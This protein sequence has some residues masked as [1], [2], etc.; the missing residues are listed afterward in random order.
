MRVSAPWR[1]APVPVIPNRNVRSRRGV[2]NDGRRN[3]AGEDRL[4]RTLDE[5]RLFARYRE[6]DDQAARDALV[7]RF[8][9]LATQ[10]ARR[11]HRGNEP[12]DDLVQVASVGLLNAIDRFDPARGIAFSSF[13][14]PTIAGELKR[15]YRDKGWAVRVPRDLQELALR[16]DR[17]TDRLV[18]QLGRAP[19]ASEIADDLGV[20]IEQVIEAHEAAAAYRAYSLDRAGSDDDQA[21]TR[22]VDTLGGDEPGYRQA[23]DSATVESLMSALSDREREILRL[24]FEE[25]LTQSEIGLRVGLSQMHISRLLRQAVARLREAAQLSE[26]PA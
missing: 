1:G 20:T 11:Y 9:P 4:A 8:L 12:L 7:E 23:E 2:A 26:E 16:V 19:T 18:H 10:L 13:A 14:V 24:R 21:G 17:A 22:V 25:D 15:H 5:R 3:G 6:R